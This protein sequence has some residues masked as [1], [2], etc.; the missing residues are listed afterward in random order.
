MRKQCLGL[1]SIF[2][3]LLLS[4]CCGE[5]W[6]G[7]QNVNVQPLYDLDL[8][9]KDVENI[10]DLI[11]L[12]IFEGNIKIQE[13]NYVWV[14][15]SGPNKMFLDIPS[16]SSM[17]ITFRLANN[18]ES[19]RE[20]FE[21]YCTKESS[22]WASSSVEYDGSQDNQY[23]ISYIQQYRTSPESLCRPMNQYVSY[24]LFQKDRLLIELFETIHSDTGRDLIFSK[25]AII[26]KLAEELEK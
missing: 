24:V 17:W 13:D 9:L 18:L 19:S 14:S 26:L 2:M 15:L 23:C 8:N 22:G 6:A 16:G 4:G 1:V 25:D 7:K 21:I 12:K 3:S 20:N 10:S 5:I 11:D